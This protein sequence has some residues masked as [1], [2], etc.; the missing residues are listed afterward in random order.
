MNLANRWTR[1]F[2]AFALAIALTIG[3]S[4]PAFADSSSAS[5]GIVIKLK[6]GSNQMTVNG[7]AVT[8]T[9]P[10]QKAGTTFVPLS[11][12]TKS[13]G[14]TLQLKDN[15]IIT[16][17]YLTHTITLTIGS[18]TAWVDGKKVALVSAPE[19]QNGVTMVPLRVVEYFGAKVAL[20]SSTKEI[21][22][23]VATAAAG[24][25][26]GIGGGIDT[27]AGKSM[28][29]DSFYKWSMNYPTGLVQQYQSS[30][31]SYLSFEDVKGDY[32]LS[33][34]V[35]EQ[36]D[37]LDADEVL[38][39]LVDYAEDD[40]IVDMKPVTKNGV[41]YQRV[42]SKSYDGFYYDYRSVQANGYLYTIIFGKAA[43]S[44]A[45]LN[46]SSSI[47]DSFKPSF[48]AANKSLKDLTKIKDGLIAFKQDEYG[49]SFS[50]PYN[51]S[52]SY[53]DSEL[54]YYS[55]KSEELY[56]YIF[57][58]HEGDTADT[59]AARDMARFKQNFKYS[60][61]PEVS[62]TTWN[63]IP[64]KLVKYAYSMDSKKWIT[65]YHVVAV[66]GN[67]KYQTIYNFLD[68]D[69]VSGEA[70]FKQFLSTFKLDFN[71]VAASIG[72]IPDPDDTTDTSAVV[73]KTSKKYGYSVTLPKHWTGESKNFESDSIQ[74]TGY[75]LNFLIYVDD[76]S[77]LTAYADLMEKQYT[78]TGAFK[79]ASKT[80]ASVAGANGYQMVFEPMPGIGADG[81]KI[82]L[83]VLEKD[84]KVFMIQGALNG[85]YATEFNVNQL[86]DALASFKF[87]N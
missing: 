75:G 4:V 48:D 1:S 62:D 31:G 57:S 77:T 12:I 64:A 59:I 8:I 3:V 81:S 2:I 72:E 35:E 11:V 52:G 86:N 26:S 17:K 74:Y 85:A 60:K 33:I 6:S 65:E 18:K 78:G 56:M 44:V 82:T 13:F 27:D 79:L 69:A 39:T 14:A 34:G 22:I 46:S 21:V 63:G 76:T 71:K 36:E 58:L 87:T 40:T 41:T 61:E 49:I 70:G 37:T 67:Y 45:D 29:G 19:V 24:S 50:L 54:Y 16:L 30:D 38:E 66:K 9:K 10:Y 68:E 53:D 15:K 42:V 25:G 83:Y 84:G 5:A 32:Y 43:K 51:W 23:S 7:S 28:I 73:T 20:N 47:L 55:D 80:A